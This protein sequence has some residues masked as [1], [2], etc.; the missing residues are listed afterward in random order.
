[1]NPCCAT[2]NQTLQGINLSCLMVIVIIII[3]III[4]VVVVVDNEITNI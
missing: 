2:P 3:S 4:V 1:M